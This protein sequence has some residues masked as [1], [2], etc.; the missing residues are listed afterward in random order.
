MRY[1]KFCIKAF[2]MIMVNCPK[3]APMYKKFK[4]LALKLEKLLGGTH[5]K[6]CGLQWPNIQFCLQCNL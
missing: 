3:S 5:R 2:P 1:N 4:F 6:G